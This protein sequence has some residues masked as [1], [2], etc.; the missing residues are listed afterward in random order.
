MNEFSET[1]YSLIRMR[2]LIYIVRHGE[3]EL[4]AGKR[5]RGFM[6]VLLD[7]NGVEQ[8][9]QARNDL[10]DIEL[11]YAYSSDLKRASKTM[12]IIL[13]GHGSYEYDSVTSKILTDM[14]PWNVGKFAG[15][16]KNAE[17]KKAL[18]GYADNP[19]EVVPD[20][21]SL[22]Q[23]RARYQKVFNKVVD[24]AKASVFNG[25]GASLMAQH[26]SNCHEVGNII[27]GD[28][29]TLDVE[30]GGIII[31]SILGNKLSASIFKG[32]AKENQP[33]TVS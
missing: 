19:D 30:P 22:N 23:F 33:D 13:Q 25:R 27:Y 29:D 9:K 6:D 11:S 12:E 14:R 18:Q 4:N 21:E 31:V 24:E 17:N 3:T 8:A 5:F 15:Q 7:E 26:A 32:A 28:I 20:G 2:P 10:S 16:P 1:P